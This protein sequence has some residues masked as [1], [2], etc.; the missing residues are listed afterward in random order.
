[1][2]DSDPVAERAEIEWK[3]TPLSAA[4]ADGRTADDQH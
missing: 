2:G 1:M 4:L 3:F